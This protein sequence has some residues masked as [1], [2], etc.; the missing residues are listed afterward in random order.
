MGG[1]DSVLIANS[2]HE[3]TNPLAMLDHT[4]R[5]LRSGGRLVILDRGPRNYQG[6]SR[7]SQIQRYTITIHEDRAE[8]LWSLFWDRLRHLCTEITVRILSRLTRL[9]VVGSAE[10]GPFAVK[11]SD[12]RFTRQLAIRPRHPRRGIDHKYPCVSRTFP[13]LLSSRN[14]NFGPCS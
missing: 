8:L 10:A 3:F 6:E 7:E 12:L 11:N 1:V 4:F 2:Y 13:C 14:K 9:C 5:A